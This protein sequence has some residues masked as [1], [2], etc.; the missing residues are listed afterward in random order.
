MRHGESI[1]FALLLFALMPLYVWAQSWDKEPDSIFG[2]KFGKR[3]E[4]QIPK[5][6]DSD[7]LQE[8]GARMCWRPYLDTYVEVENVPFVRSFSLLQVDGPKTRQ[9]K[10]CD[11]LEPDC[12]VAPPTRTRTFEGFYTGFQSSR[13]NE[14]LSVLE[15]RYCKST[16]IEKETLQTLGGAVLTS[17]RYSWLGKNVNITLTERSRSDVTKGWFTVTTKRYRDAEAAAEKKERNRA[18]DKL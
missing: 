16:N 9:I 15:K 6:R 17:M 4:D 10:K 5:C 13:V 14:Y 8:E 7:L 11:D 2:L 12:L 18:A 3:I 1:R